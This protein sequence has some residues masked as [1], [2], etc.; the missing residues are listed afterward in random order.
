[1]HLTP[2]QRSEIV[3]I[4]FSLTPK[5]SINIL[6]KQQYMNRLTRFLGL[7]IWQY[8]VVTLQQ[9]IRL[10]AL[11]IVLLSATKFTFSLMLSLVKNGFFNKTLFIASSPLSDIRTV[12]LFVL[13]RSPTSS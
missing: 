13:G 12:C 10:I 3:A 6:Q 8:C 9:P 2:N 5:R 1:M 4:Y 11:P 7:T